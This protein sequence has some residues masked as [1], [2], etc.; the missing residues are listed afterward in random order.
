MGSYV[1]EALVRAGIEHLRI[2]DFDR[3]DITNLNRQLFALESTIGTPKIEVAQR[4]IH[5]IN[6]RCKVESFP[7]FCNRDNVDELIGDSTDLV[8]DA[9]DSLGSKIE[10]LQSAYEKKVPVISS[11]GAARKSDPTKIRIGDLLTTRVCP[12]ARQIRKALKKRGIKKGITCIYSEEAALKTQV[13]HE[14]ELF[15]EDAFS[16]GKTRMVMGSLPTITGMF[17]LFM[18]NEA[19]KR[20]TD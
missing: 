16:R 19:I 9:I 8:I 12:L 15:E 6:P 3:V 5:D 4:R 17:G 14:S 11:M 20:F 1:T 18:A 7:V 13:D 10:L 2:V